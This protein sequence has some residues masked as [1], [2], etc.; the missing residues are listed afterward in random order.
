MEPKTTR[1]F[2]KLIREFFRLQAEV[3]SLAALLQTAELMDQPPIKWLDALKQMRTLQEY[4]NIS[5]QYAPL[6]AHIE[7]F[8]EAT[9]LDQ[10]IKSIPPTE[11][12]N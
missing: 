10:L 2:V 8:A 5:E 4:R 1:E 7:Q 3:R 9:E 6:L 12:L 11:F